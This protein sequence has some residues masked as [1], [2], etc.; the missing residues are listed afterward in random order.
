M[1]FVPPPNRITSSTS[2]SKVDAIT[3]TEIDPQLIHTFTNWLTVPEV[4][5]PNAIE[6]RA[7][8]TLR[9]AIPN[10]PNPGMKRVHTVSSE[11]VAKYSRP[12][13]HNCLL[14]MIAHFE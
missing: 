7:D 9:R 14:R 6:S 4:S 8:D 1:F 3:R 11:V 12:D 10:C 13:F 2:L 5:L